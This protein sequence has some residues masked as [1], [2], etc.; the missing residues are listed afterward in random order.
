MK[1]F[2]YLEIILV[3]A[4]FLT[5]GTAGGVF[6]SIFLTKNGVA[7]TVDRLVGSFRKA[8]AYSINNKDGQVWGVCVAGSNSIRMFS[9]S[10]NS[11]LKKD[12][13]EVYG[14]VSISDFGT[15][16]FSKNRGEI[17]NPVSI[18]VT[19]GG[20]QKTILINTMGVINVE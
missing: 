13:F 11:P 4:I 17:T 14:D 8:Q 18:N 7:N 16:M 6:M 20:E 3:V 12:D 10:C 1:G 9:G 15:I 19:N 5:L 2:T